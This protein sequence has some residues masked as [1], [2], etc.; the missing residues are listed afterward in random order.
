MR[1][2]NNLWG[3]VIV[4]LSISSATAVGSVHADNLIEIAI[5]PTITIFGLLLLYVLRRTSVHPDAF[6]DQQTEL[7]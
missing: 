5:A 3:S 7:V 4:G 6:A 1:F 2:L